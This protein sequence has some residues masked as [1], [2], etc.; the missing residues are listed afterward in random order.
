M[1]LR[2]TFL[3][4]SGA[5]PTARR[6]PSG[7]YLNREGEEL[8]FDC[9]EGTQRQMMRFSTGF[10]I[11]AIFLT[12]VHGDH[13]LGLPGL[14]QTLDFNDRADPLVVHTPRGTRRTVEDLVGALDARLG[15]PV[16]VREVAPGEVVRDG[17]DY[18]IQAFRTDH[19]T[20]SV[21]YVLVEADR[22]GRFDRERAEE[23][24]V[25]VGPAFGRLHAGEP[26]ELADGTVIKPEQVVGSPRP[27]RR[28]VYTGDTRPTE[29]TVDASEDADLLIHDATFGDDWAERARETGHSSAREAGELAARTG[30]KRLALTHISSRYAGDASRLANEA[31]EEHHEAFV[32]EDGL[33]I[34]VPFPE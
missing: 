23:L 7:I 15:F 20:H 8:L 9:G 32:A 19:R 33:E 21:G 11:S 34:E 5:V 17:E 29:E 6:N 26:V 14:L 22:K 28:V 2:V 24:G 31:S 3:G 4:T 18:E 10:S 27:G 25:P 30:V 1:T 13:V 12:H 16:E